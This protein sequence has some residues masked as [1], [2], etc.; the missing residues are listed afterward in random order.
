[1]AV[2]FFFVSSSLCVFCDRR[3]EGDGMRREHNLSCPLFIL[4]DVYEGES[5]RGGE[6]RSPCFFLHGTVD[7][8]QQQA[9]SGSAFRHSIPICRLYNFIPQVSEPC[10]TQEVVYRSSET[11]SS[12][13]FLIKCLV[14]SF[15]Q[16]SLTHLR[17]QSNV[18]FSFRKNTL[19]DFT[20]VC[21]L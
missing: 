20:V 21:R 7:K 1:M 4:S 2:R 6:R 10:L 9:V 3:A 12:L 16:N 5:I 17:F 15:I 18:L 14:P 19:Q 13:Y 11:D 8:W